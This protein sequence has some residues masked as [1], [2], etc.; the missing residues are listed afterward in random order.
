MFAQDDY[1]PPKYRLQLIL[2]QDDVFKAFDSDTRQ[3]FLQQVSFR[4]FLPEQLILGHHQIVD[5]VYVLINGSLQVGWLQNNGQL[6]VIN[7][8]ANY[9][10]F[11][12]VAFLQK[13][14]VNYDFFAVGQVDVALL[15]GQ[16]FLTQLQQQPQAMWQ[17]L[18]LVSQRMYALF[19]Q[20]RYTH[21]ANS[22]Q[23]IAYYLDKLAKQYGKENNNRCLISLRMTQQDF[24]ELFGISRQTLAKNLQPF[25]KQ[26]ILEWSYSQIHILD[27]QKLRQLCNL[28]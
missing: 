5:D 16:I 24:A 10:A 18:Q 23:H 13:K 15:S 21:T 1:L 22:T 4:R 19:E 11:N 6:K 27:V 2:E 26:G 9:S 3:L 17:I 28:E 8:T 14:P 12:L 7:Y 20:T 25:L